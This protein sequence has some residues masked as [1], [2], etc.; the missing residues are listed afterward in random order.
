MDQ[1]THIVDHNFLETLSGMGPLGAF[2]CAIEEYGELLLNPG[3][4][5]FL[6]AVF[7]EEAYMMEVEASLVPQDIVVG[8]HS[9][10][11]F[12]IPDP[13]L[14]LRHL[15]IRIGPQKSKMPVRMIDLFASSTRLFGVDEEV[16]NATAERDLCVLM[17]H[18]TLFVVGPREKA[19]TVDALWARF[20][21]LQVEG[22]LAKKSTLPRLQ[23][24]RHAIAST[25]VKTFA[26]LWDFE[27]HLT[28][29]GFSDGLCKLE[30]AVA[31]ITLLELGE[32]HFIAPEML[33]RGFTIGRYSRCLAGYH[34]PPSISRVHLLFFQDENGIWCVDTASMLGSTCSPEHASGEL[35]RHLRCEQSLHIVLA[36][37]LSLLWE[38]MQ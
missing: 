9:K 25:T 3:D 6:V 32:Q 34:A 10:A 18:T 36:E 8:R 7:G 17:G 35:F 21:N 37:K 33:E 4:G 1:H 22:T 27:S 13:A 30:N 5:S 2:I 12:R 11:H 16:A 19:L 29:A 15:L 31:K 26:G 20:E 38:P 23:P 14:S 28:Q 24:A